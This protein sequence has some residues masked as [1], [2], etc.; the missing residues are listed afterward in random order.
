MQR[1]Q[2]SLESEHYELLVRESRQR[3]VSL[4]AVVR[5]LIADGLRKPGRRS[6]SRAGPL[7][8]IKGLGEGTGE[9][10]GRQHNRNLYGDQRR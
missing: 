3:G 4:A 7:A 1:T 9:A 8:R 5:Q 10:V 2:I 6:R